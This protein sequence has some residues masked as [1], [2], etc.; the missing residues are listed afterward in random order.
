MDSGSPPSAGFYNLLGWLETNKKR[1]AIGAGVIAVA[2]AVAGFF[3]WRSGQQALEAEDALS[4]V[5]I[6]GPGETPPP[7]TAEALAKVAAEFPK[8]QAAPKAR[9]RAATVFFEQGNYTAAQEQF[10]K[11]LREHGDTAWV[12]QAVLGIAAC[13]DAENKAS[14]AITKYSDFI[15]KYPNDPAGDQARLSLARL[16]EQTKQPA[17]ALDVLRKMTEGQNPMGF[18][19][20]AQEAQERLRQLVAKHPELLPPPPAP[21]SPSMFTNVMSPPTNVVAPRT[22]L[23]N[24]TNL[25]RRTNPP[26]ILNTN[27]PKILQTPTP[28]QTNA[29]K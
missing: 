29:A 3:A 7:G 22:N 10:Q 21:I 26:L 11:F 6:F 28:G 12:P 15:A 2:A 5:R 13:L 1:V 24:L 4:S 23:L 8:T 16:Y 25:I 17:Q 18:S 20:G 27:A 14:E 19:P 9:L